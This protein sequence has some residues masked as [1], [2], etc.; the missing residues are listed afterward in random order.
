MIYQ[1]RQ[2]GTVP[3]LPRCA[4]HL[5]GKAQ[6]TEGNRLAE[7][8]APRWP[9]VEQQQPGWTL[10]LVPLPSWGCCRLLLG[11]L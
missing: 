3:E 9:H 6:S 11:S 4:R 8:Q 10:C 1:V 2:K 5:A 7:E